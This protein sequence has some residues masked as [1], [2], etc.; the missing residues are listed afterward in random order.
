MVDNCEAEQY[1]IDFAKI[2]T[3]YNYKINLHSPVFID[4]E[5]YKLYIKFAVQIANINR[6]KINRVFH[7]LNNEK[8]KISLE[9]LNDI[10]GKKRLKK[11][12]LI[13]FLLKTK[14]IGFFIYDIGHEN[15]KKNY[16]GGSTFLEL[17]EAFMEG[18]EIYLWN[19]IPEGI[20]FDEISGF[21]PK[22]IN[23]NLDL[24]K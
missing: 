22:I 15:G 10:K 9:N 17:Y 23:G 19:E 5:K 21:S 6:R 16:V 8:I 4:I 18:K 20:L 12:N 7:P 24:V 2:A 11:E 14:E 1:L 3:R 13:D